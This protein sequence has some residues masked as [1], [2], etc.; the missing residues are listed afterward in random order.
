MAKLYKFRDADGAFDYERY[1]AIQTA[2]NKAKLEAVFAVEE[3]I[4]HLARRILEIR[5]A[6]TFGICHGTRKGLEQAWFSDALD[7]PV[8]GTE[9]SDTAA[10]FPNTIQWDFH[11]LKDEWIGQ[12]DFVYSNSWDHA[13]D[14]KTCFDHWVQCLKPGGLMLLDHT[15]RHLPDTVNPVDPFGASIDELLR[16]LDT[17]GGETYRVLEVVEDLPGQV[18]E[19]VL[20][21]TVSH[22]VTDIRTIIAQKSAQ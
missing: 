11:E 14:P 20:D 16:L 6:C 17:W 9:I 13:Y 8:L 12:A 4:R 19:L 3:N 1:K 2:A 22:E 15:S 18:N 7:C 5:G 10:L 21:D